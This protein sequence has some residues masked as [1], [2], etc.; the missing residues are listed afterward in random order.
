MLYPLFAVSPVVPSCR[1]AQPC[2]LLECRDASPWPREGARLCAP[3][4]CCRL[5]MAFAAFR[6]FAGRFTA[7]GFGLDLIGEVVAAEQAERFG[8]DVLLRER[9]VGEDLAART[10]RA[11]TVEADAS[12]LAPCVLLPAGRYTGFD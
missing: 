11:V 4:I 7:F 5:R 1:G 12:A 3:K 2:A 9:E 8:G 6:F 10:G